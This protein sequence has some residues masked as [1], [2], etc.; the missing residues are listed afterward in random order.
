MTT[1]YD[2]ALTRAH[3]SNRFAQ[4]LVHYFTDTFG[5]EL[6]RGIVE[7]AGLSLDYLADPER[8]ISVEFDRRFCDAAARRIHGLVDPP[9][10]E[11]PLWQHWR[12][13]SAAM[14]RRQEMGPH[15]LLLWAMDGPREFFRDIDRLYSSG[16]RVT[17]VR[18]AGYEPGRAVIVAE[19]V[20]ET[21]ARPGACWS[22]RGLFEAIPSIWG[23]PPA[24]VDHPA[25][26]HQ[27]EGVR[28][29]R[30]EVRFTERVTHDPYAELRRV[31]QHVRAV[32]PQLLGQMERLQR[33]HR[34]A[35]LAQRKVGAYLPAH[36]LEDSRINPEDE[37]RL[38]G[39]GIEGAVL[40]ADLAGFTRRCD[41]V[42]AAAV[43]DQLNLYFEIMDEVIAAHGGILDKRMGDGLMVVF[44][45]RDRAADRAELGARALACGLAMLRAL[46][47]CNARLAAQGGAPL[48]MRVGVAAGG[49]VQ[50]NVGSRA[51]LEHTVIGPPVNL[52]ARLEAA[53][54]PGTLLALRE[55]AGGLAGDGV[56][57]VERTIDAKGI[58][59]LAAI[60]LR[61]AP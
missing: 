58:G 35:L 60:E 31:R 41:E 30:Y 32:I 56:I 27:H 43:L 15:W 48:A 1:R 59:A 39:Q 12:D 3:L 28:A 9:P 20:G 6:A 11:H 16:N 51:R 37:V 33:E 34:E 61:P 7:D 38:G 54:T 47:R 24:R 53:A 14:L 40:C 21:L 45:A 42:G 13:A 26:A 22:R 18:L 5:E 10:Y 17:R 52:A 55:L 57:G 36:V 44:V 29:C 19:L 25:C 50:G 8:W 2:P 23:L 49:L 46:P 4:N